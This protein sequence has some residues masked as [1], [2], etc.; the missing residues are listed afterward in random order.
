METLRTKGRFYLPASKQNQV[1][2]ILT[3]DNE[4]GTTLDLLGILTTP[5]TEKLLIQGHTS[6]G[7]SLTLYHSY[8]TQ[9]TFGLKGFNTSILYSKFLFKGLFID[10]PRDLYFQRIESDF[11]LLTSWINQRRSF[12]IIFDTKNS[13][14]LINSK[15]S[16]K[17]DIQLPNSDNLSI[18]FYSTSK[19]NGSPITEAIIKQKNSIEFTCQR[20][21]NFD[22][23]M[24]LIKHFQNFLTFATLKTIY[25]TQVNVFFRL[26]GEKKFRSSELLFP[27]S[28]AKEY[29]MNK[30]SPDEFLLPFASIEASFDRIIFRWFEIRKKLHPIISEYCSVF[31]TPKMFY[32][33]KFL[34]VTRCMESFHREFRNSKDISNYYRYLS[35]YKEGRQTFNKLL[36]I[37][38]STEFCKRLKT[39]RNDLTH[40]N[41]KSTI[42]KKKGSDLITLTLQSRI[43]FTSALLRELG[44]T[45]TEIKNILKTTGIFKY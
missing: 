29:D 36:K 6:E 17:I 33:D 7:E 16:E 18:Y 13:T 2:G 1:P 14:T 44:L 21:R 45:N 43:I 38:S 5:G 28:Y 15:K 20:R 9:F 30:L 10:S 25:P 19:F 27:I 32:E 41:Q 24:D 31:Y 42:D 40:K 23:L 12:E 39:L 22:Y 8:F 11:N 3:F 26:K 35:L 37:K 34:S 4:K